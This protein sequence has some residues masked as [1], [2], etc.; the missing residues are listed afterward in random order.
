MKLLL[1]VATISLYQAFAFE[2]GDYYASMVYCGTDI[3]AYP[4]CSEVDESPIDVLAKEVRIGRDQVFCDGE[5]VWDYDGETTF[6]V[7]KKEHTV[8]VVM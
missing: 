8:E 1:L 5:F 3:I 7:E 4:F 2:Y 6:P